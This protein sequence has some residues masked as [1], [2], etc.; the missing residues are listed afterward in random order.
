LVNPALSS[1][2]GEDLAASLL[3]SNA[4]RA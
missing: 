3:Q 4:G 2:D 1:S